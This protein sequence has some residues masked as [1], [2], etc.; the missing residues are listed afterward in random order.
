MAN[1]KSVKFLEAMRVFPDGIHPVTVSGGQVLSLSAALADG[2]VRD[3][4]ATFSDAKPSDL[5]IDLKPD[6]SKEEK[7]SKDDK[8]DKTKK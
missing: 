3:K 6:L 4:M 7:D 8:D 5:K 2:L 1:V